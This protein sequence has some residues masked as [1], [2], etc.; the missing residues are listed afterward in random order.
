MKLNDIFGKDGCS[1]V[2]EVEPCVPQFG[3]H[4]DRACEQC[5]GE[6]VCTHGEATH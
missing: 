3:N 5:G 6:R 2:V 4:C 1:A